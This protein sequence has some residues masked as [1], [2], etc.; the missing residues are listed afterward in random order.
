MVFPM[1]DYSVTAHLYLSI[2]SPFPPSSPAPLPSCSHHKY[3]QGGKRPVLRQLEDSE[4]KWKKTQVNGS[5]YHFMRISIVL[6]K[7]PIL[8]NFSYSPLNTLQSG[9][10]IVLFSFQSHHALATAKFSGHLTFLILLDPVAAFDT[11]GIFSLKH[12]L[13]CASGLAL[14]L[15]LLFFHFPFLVIP[16]IPTSKFWCS[17]T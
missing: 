12:F 8:S 4:E 6:S 13:F 9:L 1:C 10:A 16:Y 11:C 17:K 14:F 7:M 5:I 15:P 3:N 2:A